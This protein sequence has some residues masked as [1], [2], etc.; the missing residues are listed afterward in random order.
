MQL[1]EAVQNLKKAMKNQAVLNHH[2]VMKNQAVQEHQEV[3]V[4]LLSL[5]KSIFPQK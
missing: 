1:K 4:C 3:R 5:Y 2:Q